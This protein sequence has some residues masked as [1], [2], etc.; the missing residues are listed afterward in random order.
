[1]FFNNKPDISRYLRFYIL[2]KFVGYINYI[3]NSI[4]I[5]K[6]SWRFRNFA[7][8][9]LDIIL[10][11]PLEIFDKNFEKDFEKT[12]KIT[13]IDFKKKIKIINQ[14]CYETNETNEIC[15]AKIKHIQLSQKQNRLV[16]FAKKLI[17]ISTVL[18]SY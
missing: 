3:N 11:L 18:I 9:I 5:F 12:S 15:N 10:F 14:E 1:M 17:S 13:L 8:F 6:L 2:Y 4:L 7:D 16:S